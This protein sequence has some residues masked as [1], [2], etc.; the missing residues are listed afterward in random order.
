LENITMF[1]NI[2]VVFDLEKSAGCWKATFRL[3]LS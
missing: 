1:P 2:E 3:S